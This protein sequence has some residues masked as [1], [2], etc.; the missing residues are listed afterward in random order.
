MSNSGHFSY[1]TVREHRVFKCSVAFISVLMQSSV[2]FCGIC[3]HSPWLIKA[4]SVCAR[5]VDLNPTPNKQL[6][7]CVCLLIF[8]LNNLRG[9]FWPSVKTYVP[10]VV[11]CPCTTAVGTHTHT[12]RETWHG[13]CT[14]TP[15]QLWLNHKHALQ[16][17]VLDVSQNLLICLLAF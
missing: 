4:G 13:P 8:L 2:D 6:R 1:T 9:S 14:H 3:V 16:C 17:R 12:Q 10:A 5:P 15:T 7:L 11:L